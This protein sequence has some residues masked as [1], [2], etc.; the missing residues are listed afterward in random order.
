[1]TGAHVTFDGDGF[2]PR[3]AAPTH[4]HPLP[5]VVPLEVRPYQ[6]MRAGIVSR[7]IANTIDFAVL[8]IALVALYL[9]INGVRFLWNARSFRFSSVDRPIALVV[10][11]VVLAVYLAG[12]WA[13]AGRTIGDHILGLRVVARGGAPIHFAVAVARALIC[14]VFPIGIFWVAVSPADRSVAD[15][16]L[17]TSVCYDW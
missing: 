1:M 9:G 10:A 3:A 2:A 12:A 16:I 7:L 5:S 17:R 11:G 8:A 13:L 4:D 6:G 15:A 14:V